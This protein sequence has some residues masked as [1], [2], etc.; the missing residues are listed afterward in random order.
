MKPVPTEIPD[1][2]RTLTQRDFSV[3]KTKG[4]RLKNKLEEINMKYAKKSEFKVS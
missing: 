2:K 3:P 1:S 4:K